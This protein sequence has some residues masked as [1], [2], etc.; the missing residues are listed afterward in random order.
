MLKNKTN[1]MTNDFF[2]VDQSKCVKCALCVRDCAFRALRCGADGYPEINKPESCMRCQ[3]CFAICPKG[4]I[5]FNGKRA[6]DSVQTANLELPSAAAVSNWMRVR[7]S[8]RHFR[9]GDVPREKL[10]R[11]LSALGN[12]PTGCNARALTFT[13][14]STRESMAAFKAKFLRELEIYRDG[15]KMLPRWLAVPAIKMRK[16]GE[17]VFFRNAAGMVVISCDETAPGVVTPLQDIAAACAYFEMLAQAEGLATC[18]CGFLDLVKRDV[19]TIA[20]ALGLRE[21]T[22]FYAMLFGESAVR[23]VRGVQRDDEAQVIWL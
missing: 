4:A 22:P 11:I 9:D 10:E 14:Y 5:E 12:T 18:W 2:K 3:H 17:D 1:K 23:Y 7:R 16:G 6:E 8:V 15:N 13:C 20:R 19:P 21:T